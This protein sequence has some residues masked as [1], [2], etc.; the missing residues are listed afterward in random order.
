MLKRSIH[1]C[2]LVVLIAGLSSCIFDPKKDDGKEPPPPPYKFL[3]LTEKQNVLL[4][5]EGAYTQR[6]ID[7][8]DEAL[9][10][11]FTFFL[12]SGDVGNNLPEQWDRSEEILLNTRL[13]DK[14]YA[15]KPC[16]KIE[17]DI[18]T[19]EGLQWTEFT[20]EGAPSE[21]WYSTTVYYEFRFEINP[22]IF[23]SQPGSR[24]VFTVRDDGT[25]APDQHWQLVEFRD[26]GNQ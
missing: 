15:A 3:A 14:T 26:L 22:D 21:T 19:E 12:S 9:D 10:D 20:P 4:N 16:Q 5:I 11:G 8:Y 23:I 25:A 7:K 17:M 2:I 18:R 24:G 13:F 6:R 1:L